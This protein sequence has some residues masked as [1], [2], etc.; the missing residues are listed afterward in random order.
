MREDNYEEAYLALKK[1]LPFSLLE[2]SLLITIAADSKFKHYPRGNYVFQKGDKSLKTLFIVIEGEARV[3]TGTELDKEMQQYAG[4]NYR[5]KGEF[6]GE[7][8]FLSKD[9]PYPASVEAATKLKC[10]LISQKSFLKALAGSREFADYFTKALSAR[11]KDLYQSF[12]FDF[13]GHEKQHLQ[14]LR[15]GIAEVANPKLVTCSPDAGARDIAFTMQRNNVSMVLVT[16]HEEKPLGIITDKDLVTKVLASDKPD[17]KTPADR[18]MSS[19]LITADPYS[20]VYQSLFLMVKHKIH[21]LVI[22]GEDCKPMGIVTAHDLVYSADTGALNLIHQ[23]EEQ[24]TVKGLA[25]LMPALDQLQQAF[26]A[27]RAYASEICELVTE[28][29]DWVT[30][31]II[32]LSEQEMVDEGWGEPPAN[33][34]FINMGS[35]GRREQFSRTDQDNGIIYENSPAS[36]DGDCSEYFLTLGDKIVR[37]LEACGFRRCKGGIMADSPKW[38]MPLDS[39][40]KCVKSWVDL[41]K[42]DSIRDMTV[43]LDFRYLYGKEDLYEDLKDYVT[44]LF[45]KSPYALLFMTEDDLT[46]QV[47]L[48][49]FKQIITERKG[50]HRREINLKNAAGL[51]MLDCLRIFSLRE[52][53][54]ETNT[55]QR[56]RRLKEFK[57]FPDDTAEYIEAAYETIMMLRIRDAMRKKDQG[58]EPD[59]Y[60]E[61]GTLSKKEQALLKESLLVANKLQSLTAHAFKAR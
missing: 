20:H 1:L 50:R 61:P 12:Y 3:I 46:H 60:I 18:I 7:T 4:T 41:L 42:P 30:R 57:V 52:G 32:A 13:T 44:R 19:P 14:P 31:K 43:F 15:R 39:W 36:F 16:D 26:L 21:H 33:Y 27:E 38:C 25:S 56:I 40:K 35:A 34:C 55:F 17:L 29:Y 24:T 6:F 9:D 37:G 11:L 49:M 48:N 5:R 2:D 28:L 10:L 54:R 22:T 8:V 51:H 23:I 47:P 58:L 59:N 45:Q 53:I